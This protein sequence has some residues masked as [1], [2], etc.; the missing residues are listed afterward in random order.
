MTRKRRSIESEKEEIDAELQCH[1]NRM[2]LLLR[3]ST[4]PSDVRASSLAL[5]DRAC[6][7]RETDTHFVLSTSAYTCGTETEEKNGVRVYRNTVLERMTGSIARRRAVN[8]PFECEFER[9]PQSAA[10]LIKYHRPIIN[11]IVKTRRESYYG[12]LIEMFEDDTFTTQKQDSLVEVVADRAMFFQVSL[13][14]SHEFDLTLRLT[15]CFGRP[16]HNLDREEQYVF[17]ENDCPR[18]RTVIFY[19]SNALDRV[20]FSVQPF[21]FS[22]RPDNVVINCYVKACSKNLDPTCSQG[23]QHNGEVKRS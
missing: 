16:Q 17:I 6:A 14:S 12:V 2:T 22:K 23:C 4:L 5:N 10:V 8:I 9:I 1:T 3:K 15:K 18:D 20:R 19:P 7:A 13:N 21:A 11:R